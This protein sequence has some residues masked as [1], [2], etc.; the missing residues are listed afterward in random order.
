MI[1]TSAPETNDSCQCADPKAGNHS[2][3][4][5]ANEMNDED[6]HKLEYAAPRKQ[7]MEPWLAEILGWS[8]IGIIIA[9]AIFCLAIFFLGVYSAFP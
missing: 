2:E 5:E 8:S 4:A 6:V 3:P 1:K 7:T 9:I